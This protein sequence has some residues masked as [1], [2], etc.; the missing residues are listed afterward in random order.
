[1]KANLYRDEAQKA[2][3]ACKALQAAKDGVAEVQQAGHSLRGEEE[4]GSGAVEEGGRRRC[5]GCSS[6]L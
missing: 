3:N 4:A 2:R 1:M 6:M 5:G